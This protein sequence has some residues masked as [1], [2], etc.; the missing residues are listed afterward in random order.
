M[1]N[2]PFWSNS[3]A[4]SLIISKVYTKMENAGSWNSGPEKAT[5]GYL[6]WTTPNELKFH[7]NFYGI[8]KNYWSNNYQR[9]PTRWAQPTWAHQGA[10]ACQGAQA[11]PG[12][13]CP[14]RPTTGAHLLVYK[15]F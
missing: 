2:N 12:G 13:L 7:R 14:P 5:S 1:Y 9:G 11:R 3:N 8:Y 15:S 10:Q 4:L 6:F